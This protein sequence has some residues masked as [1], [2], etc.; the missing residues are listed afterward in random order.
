MSAATNPPRSVPATPMLVVIGLAASL[1]HAL[2]MIPGYDED[3]D[4]DLGAW[5]VMFGVSIV[6]A[7]IVFL[8]VV[9]RTRSRAALVLALLGLLTCAVFWA[10]ISLPL[11]A[12]ALVLALRESRAGRNALAT[13]VLI[14]G[15]L[16]VVALGVIIISDA[17]AN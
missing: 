11:S 2:A 10:M 6:V 8:V 4:F 13:T 5:G 7:L 16:A 12:G 9:P 17:V 1:I 15:A 3:G 14:I